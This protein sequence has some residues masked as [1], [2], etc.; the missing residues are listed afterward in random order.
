[1]GCL[2]V[3]IITSDFQVKT[4]WNWM[5]F[6]NASWDQ[7]CIEPLLYPSIKVDKEH[8]GRREGGILALLES[9]TTTYKRKLADWEEP[10]PM[11]YVLAV[12][13]TNGISKNTSV[14]RHSVQLYVNN[15]KVGIS[16]SHGG[17]KPLRTI[18]DFT[19]CGRPWNTDAW[20]ITGK[21]DGNQLGN[22]YPNKLPKEIEENADY[23]YK[24][25]LKMIK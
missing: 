9:S 18:D 1:M 13:F 6:D 3:G 15:H 19:V 11:D 12:F 7:S 4:R 24:K 2:F 21:I 5:G 23:L 14:N 16:I 20:V 22:I 10:R 8:D 17:R 25:V